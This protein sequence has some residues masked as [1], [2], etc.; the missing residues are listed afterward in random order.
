MLMHHTQKWM[1]AEQK[2]DVTEVNL[3]QSEHT[4]TEG[5]MSNNLHLIKNEY[6]YPTSEEV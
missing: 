2:L 3:Q 5:K 6:I 4:K 1:N